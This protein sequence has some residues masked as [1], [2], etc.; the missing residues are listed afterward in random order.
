M[1]VLLKNPMH[2]RQNLGSN[3][4]LPPSIQIRKRPSRRL[5]PQ[6]DPIELFDVHLV[7]G[8]ARGDFEGEAIASEDGG[9]DAKDEALDGADDG[10]GVAIGDL[11]AWGWEVEVGEG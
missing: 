11:A 6:H 8:G 4:R 9:G 7:G 3:R 1:N 2:K 10:G 5:I